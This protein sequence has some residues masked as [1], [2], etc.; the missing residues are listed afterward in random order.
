MAIGVILVNQSLAI[1]PAGANS[2]FNYTGPG[3]GGSQEQITESGLIG[4]INYYAGLS[5]K[6]EY[7]GFENSLIMPDSEL[8]S[9]SDQNTDT[10]SGDEVLVIIN[11]NSLIASANF[12]ENEQKREIFNYEVKS[13]DTPS[14]IADNFGISTNTLLW[15]NNLDLNSAT[16]IKPG[17]KLVILPV[18]GIRHVIKKGETF[19]TIAKKYSADQEKILSYNSLGRQ[20]ALEID[21]VII[22]PDGKMPVPPKPV[23]PKVTLAYAASNANTAGQSGVYR[24]VTDEQFNS[25]NTEAGDNHP[26][27]H[28]RRFIWGQCTYYAALRRYIPWS[29]NAKYWL[30]NARAFGYKTGNAPIVGAIMATA[31]NPRYG[32]VAYVEAVNG[33]KITISEMN[34][35]G[36]GIKSIRVI[37]ANNPV[38]RGYIYDK[39]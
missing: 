12:P 36:V 24:Y 10:A 15:A 4:T 19:A 32:H 38:I 1:N 30:K 18:S 31:E 22:I 28:G 14:A 23:K 26:P 37:S 2:L 33:D 3:L 29:G 8:N 27:V 39:E 25:I 6:R 34:F 9:F 11:N 21:S 17:D 5:S 20:D 35:I 13:G 7:V 16:R